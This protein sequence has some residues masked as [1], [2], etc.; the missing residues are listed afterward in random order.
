MHADRKAARSA[1]Q[2]FAQRRSTSE[3]MNI[4]SL[5]PEPACA[6]HSFKGVHSFRD[7]SRAI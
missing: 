6:D 4:S 2:G 7:C 5:D 3:L 1:T